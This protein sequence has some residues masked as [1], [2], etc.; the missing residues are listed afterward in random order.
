MGCGCMLATAGVES[1]ISLSATERVSNGEP[2]PAAAAAAAA[3]SANASVDAD[4]PD[5]ACWRCWCNTCCCNGVCEAAPAND[6]SLPVVDSVSKN[7]TSDGAASCGA[8]CHA[9]ATLGGA[10]SCGW[11]ATAAA[12]VVVV[13]EAMLVTLSVSPSVICATLNG[14][15]AVSSR[16]LLL[17]GAMASLYTDDASLCVTPSIDGN[18]TYTQW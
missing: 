10:L 4:K 16:V 1:E 18:C 12:V 6:A 13:A 2:A 3:G 5:M 15:G 11:T 8:A 14:G 9:S 17:G 7:D